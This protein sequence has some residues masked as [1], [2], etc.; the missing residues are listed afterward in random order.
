MVGLGLM[1]MIQRGRKQNICLTQNKKG[2]CL[3]GVLFYFRQQP[4]QPAS[5]V[6]A[7]WYVHKSLFGKMGKNFQEKCH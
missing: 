5:G 4:F 2:R 7:V 6:P 3:F 1:G